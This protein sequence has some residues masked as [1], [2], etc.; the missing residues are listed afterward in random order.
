MVMV[1]GLLV[2][3]QNVNVQDTIHLL[4]VLGLYSD[5]LDDVSWDGGTYNKNGTA[6]P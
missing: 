4:A 5:Y 2:L 3:V 6:H 1:Y